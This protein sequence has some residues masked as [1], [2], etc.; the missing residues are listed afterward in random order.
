MIKEVKMPEKFKKGIA[1][2]IINKVIWG[3]SHF[4]P[5]KA[6]VDDREQELIDEAKRLTQHND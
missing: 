3:D 6:K 1:E 4:N 2:S 5:N